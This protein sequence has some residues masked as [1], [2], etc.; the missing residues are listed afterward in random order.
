MSNFYWLPC[1]SGPPQGKINQEEQTVLMYQID[2]LEHSSSSLQ[3]G[4]SSLY[5]SASSES[6]LIS[7]H[8]ST[9]SSAHIISTINRKRKKSETQYGRIWGSMNPF[10][11]WGHPRPLPIVRTLP[12]SLRKLLHPTRDKLDQWFS[13]YVLRLWAGGPVALRVCP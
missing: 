11:L 13:E 7:F 6:N 9:A 3:M 12:S 1:S 4:Q 10:L 2:S 5:S 8:E